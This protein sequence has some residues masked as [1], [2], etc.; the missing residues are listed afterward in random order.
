[1][2]QLPELPEL[3]GVVSKMRYMKAGQDEDLDGEA[4]LEVI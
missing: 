3:L 2:V 1:M 4:G